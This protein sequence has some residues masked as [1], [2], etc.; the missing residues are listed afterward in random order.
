M[1]E[2]PAS[3][4]DP[5]ATE[6]QIESFIARFTPETA[7]LIRAGRKALR[8]RMPAATEL[9][10]D[11]YNALAI[12]FGST[13]RTSDVVVSLACYAS[14]VLLYFYYGAA[15]ADPDGLLRG[16]GNQGRHIRLTRAALIADPGVE[17][18]IAAALDHARQP[19]PESGEGRA[20][21]RMISPRQRPRRPLSK[22]V[23]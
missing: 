14:G 6:R 10:Y 13:A 7:A 22:E 8:A 2:Q 20:V 11:N 19:M 1:T 18:L 5:A 16:K 12:G 15:L 9:V 17:A 3:P 4:D 21:V 23:A